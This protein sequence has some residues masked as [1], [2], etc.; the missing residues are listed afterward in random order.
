M[1]KINFTATRQESVFHNPFQKNEPLTQPFEVR[2]DP[3]TG[4]KSIFNTGLEGKA[5]ILFPDT[6]YDYMA[7][8]SV[9]VTDAPEMACFMRLVDRQNV[10]PHHRT[11]DYFF[12]KLL[13]NELIVNPPEKLAQWMKTGFPG[14]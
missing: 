12:Q 10:T 5:Q 4:H 2:T 3:L 9:P 1:T 13:K 6:D 11:D 8:L 7:P 14:N